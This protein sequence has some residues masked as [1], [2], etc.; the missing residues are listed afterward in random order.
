MRRAGSSHECSWLPHGPPGADTATCAAPPPLEP[1][2]LPRPPV[3][4][5]ARP[6]A[7]PLPQAVAPSSEPLV[8]KVLHQLGLQFTE[9]HMARLGKD[10]HCLHPHLD[11]LGAWLN[12]ALEDEQHSKW[13]E[14]APGGQ[15]SKQATCPAAVLA[16]DLEPGT[17]STAV[18]ISPLVQ[19]PVEHLSPPGGALRPL[20]NLVLGTAADLAAI[21]FDSDGGQARAKRAGASQ[22]PSD[23]AENSCHPEGFV[24]SRMQ[25]RSRLHGMAGHRAWM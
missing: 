20:F 5:A 1:A 21:R 6:S 24:R 11:N 16:H 13:A 4:H 12:P 10:S 2:A 23:T 25:T 22:L 15:A 17:L 19:V 8:A 18:L 7:S 3:A 14:A 9:A